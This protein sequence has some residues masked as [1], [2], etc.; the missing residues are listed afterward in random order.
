MLGKLGLFR[1][2]FTIISLG[3]F[4]LTFAAGPTGQP[5]SNTAPM[6]SSSTPKK[7]DTDLIK[8]KYWNT[9]APDLSVVQNRIYTKSGRINLQLTGG[10]INH[11]PFLTTN[12]LTASLGLNISEAIGLHF[13]YMKVLEKNSPAVAALLDAESKAGSSLYAPNLNP[14]NSIVG[15]EVSLAILYGKLSLLGKAILHFDLFLLGGGGL[16]QAQNGSSVAP[17]LGIGQQIYITHFVA[18]RADYR[19]LGY[20]ENVIEQNSVLNKGAVLNSRFTLAP[21][22]N[23]GFSFY[24]F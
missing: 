18:F 3:I 20:S 8:N 14:I 7:V 22:F 12:S 2:A 21:T 16:L 9:G 11:D 24:L 6:R 19:Y 4:N 13:M 15:G 1:F 23:L 17:W 10:F 5:R